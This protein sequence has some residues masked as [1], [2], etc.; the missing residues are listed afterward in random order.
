MLNFQFCSFFSFDIFKLVRLYRRHVCVCTMLFFSF[1]FSLLCS[2]LKFF[3]VVF[4]SSLVLNVSQS[5]CLPACLPARFRSPRHFFL[6]KLYSCPYFC[7]LFIYKCSTSNLKTIQCSVFALN[8]DISTKTS[9]VRAVH[10][11]IYINAVPCRVYKLM[12]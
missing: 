4:Q 9:L 8:P 7:L 1:L 11:F 3:F 2:L 5:A 10:T 12:S 6:I